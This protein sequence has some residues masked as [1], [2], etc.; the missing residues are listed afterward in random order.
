[1]IVAF[2]HETQNKP[3]LEIEDNQVNQIVVRF[4][5]RDEHITIHL[6]T[7]G[8]LL[9]THYFPDKPSSVWD[10]ERVN[11][12]K[13]LNI[14]TPERH[15]NYV[16]N[17]LL[18]KFV[19]GGG[20]HLVGRLVDLLSLNPRQQYY[21]KIEKTLH[22]PADKFMLTV[23]LST[24]DN[25]CDPQFERVPTSLGDVCFAISKST[26]GAKGKSDTRI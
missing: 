12:A 14:N 9:R 15:G 18:P 26:T 21:R 1:M 25:S 6:R 17:S 10:E 23:Y 11:T 5:S 22:A 3:V 4:I 16:I 7:D 20:Y 8:K 2:H 19:N 24:I 13:K